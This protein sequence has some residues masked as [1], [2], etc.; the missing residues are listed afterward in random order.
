MKVY[1]FTLCLF[2]LSCSARGEKN[3]YV[4]END[5]IKQTVTINYINE[6]TINFNLTS[7]NKRIDKSATIEG[8][9]KNE[10]SDFGSENDADEEGNA[11]FVDEYI[12]VGD[13]WLS[14]RIDMDTQTTMRV[15]LAD[16]E[17]NPYCPFTSINLL[18]KIK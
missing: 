11:Y 8:E 18:Q 15:T 6:N 13:C 14:F 2:F 1:F 7:Y 9:A 10:Y 17:E 16:C 4:Y 12:Y 5:T 3:D